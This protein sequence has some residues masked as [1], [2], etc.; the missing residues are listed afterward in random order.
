MPAEGVPKFKYPTVTGVVINKDPP[1]ILGGLHGRAHDFPLGSAS[2]DAF[3]QNERPMFFFLCP[4][5]SFTHAAYLKINVEALKDRAKRFP[6]HTL[7]VLV[8]EPT[9]LILLKKALPSASV[10]VWN[11]NCTADVARFAAPPAEP[12]EAAF[13]AV[14]NAR[15]SGYKRLELAGRTERLC[16]ISRGFGPQ[17]V[18][19]LRASLP[20]AYIPNIGDDS[21]PRVL[22]PEEVAAILLRSGCGLM[23]SELEGQTRAIMEYLLCGLPVV[24]T[25]NYGGR[26]RF[27][28]PSNSLFAAPDP[29][30]VAKMVKVA[31]RAGFDRHAIRAEAIRAMAVERHLLA[32]I[33]NEVI[34]AK[35][36]KRIALEDLYLPH[37]TSSATNKLP[38]FFMELGQDVP[39]QD[40]FVSASLE[41][42]T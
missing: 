3:M 25:P 30:S 7:T 12:C 17:H 6:Q 41:A 27:L 28:T 20:G 42:A 4:Q 31:Q 22:P 23:L 13:D 21:L 32:E 29:V 2:L 39:P 9:D 36:E 15:F 8:N 33:I 16:L 26:D 1:I 37:K 24:T 18:E 11:T 40:A 14:Y 34:G 5:W 10:F 19:A 38:Y 35:G